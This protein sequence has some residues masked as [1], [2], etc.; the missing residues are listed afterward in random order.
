MNPDPDQ[1]GRP[2]SRRQLLKLA[3]SASALALW[4]GLRPALGGDGSDPARKRLMLG[5][6]G[7]GRMGLGHL[8][9]FLNHPEV[10]VVAI[11]DADPRRREHGRAEVERADTSYPACSVYSDFHDLLAR[12]DIDAVIF[13][14]A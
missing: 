6:V 8:R 10:Q 9:A 4:L 7:M 3:A 11:A 5:I 13:A 12:E 14:A 1:T 2:V